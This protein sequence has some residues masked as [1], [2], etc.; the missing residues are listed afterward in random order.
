[1]ASGSLLQSLYWNNGFH[2]VG[3]G[4]DVAEVVVGCEIWANY[5]EI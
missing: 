3:Q 2:N 4:H 5:E 1:M